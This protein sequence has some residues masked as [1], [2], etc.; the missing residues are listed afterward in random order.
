MG[1]DV[2]FDFTEVGPHVR[3]MFLDG[4]FVV[5]IKRDFEMVEEPLLSLDIVWGEG[6]VEHLPCS[7]CVRQLPK[8]ELN[9]QQAWGSESVLDGCPDVVGCD[10]DPL[11]VNW[12]ALIVIESL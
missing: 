9:Y 8:N 5:E 1:S 2:L 3:P 6:K 10:L 4:L 7:S 12:L 11:W